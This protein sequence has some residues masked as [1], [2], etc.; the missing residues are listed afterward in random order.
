MEGKLRELM[1]NV[2]DINALRLYRIFVSFNTEKLYFFKKNNFLNLK[3]NSFKFFIFKIS[4]LNF[5]FKNYVF[6]FFILKVSF[7]NF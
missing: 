4:F 5:Y 7:L 1:S 2:M 6:E 3:K